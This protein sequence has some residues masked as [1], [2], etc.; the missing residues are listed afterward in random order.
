MISMFVNCAKAWTRLV[1]F[2]YGV[3]RR[4][5]VTLSRPPIPVRT[6]RRRRG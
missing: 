2:V 1:R 4:P 6:D 3:R 5:A